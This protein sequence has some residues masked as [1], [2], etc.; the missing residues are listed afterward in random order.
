MIYRCWPVTVSISVTRLPS[1]LMSSGVLKF[2]RRA[3]RKRYL[4]RQR[5]AAKS[6]RRVQRNITHSRK[7]R[8]PSA[9]L[10]GHFDLIA[11]ILFRR[12][13]GTFHRA[14][15]YAPTTSFENNCSLERRGR[16]GGVG[17]RKERALKIHY[18]RAR[19]EESKGKSTRSAE[20]IVNRAR[21]KGHGRIG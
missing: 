10:P 7:T 18:Y 14:L 11:T 19:R 1:F 4:P 6:D 17:G 12:I 3:S 20:G 16:E 5:P 8:L 9:P 15:R 13:T 2:Q 21:V